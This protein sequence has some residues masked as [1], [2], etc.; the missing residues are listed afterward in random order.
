MSVPPLPCGDRTH[1]KV[2]NAPVLE[3]SRVECERFQFI[4][5]KPFSVHVL[6][7][8]SAEP[9]PAHTLATAR[10]TLASGET[11]I[12]LAVNVVQLHVHTTLGSAVESPHQA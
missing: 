10:D 4:L 11:D 2:A 9:F 3:G 8:G 12:P 6:V 7:K 5:I 1:A